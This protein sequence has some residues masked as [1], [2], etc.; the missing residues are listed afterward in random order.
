[1]RIII[2][3]MEIFLIGHDYRYA[4][5]Q[6]LLTLW[7]GERPVYPETPGGGDSVTITLHRGT[8]YVSAPVG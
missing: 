2:F 5:E 1:M 4:V 6:M 8:K 3:I 7:P